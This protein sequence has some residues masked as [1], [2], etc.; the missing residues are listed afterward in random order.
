MESPLYQDLYSRDIVDLVIA[1]REGSVPVIPEVYHDDGAAAGAVD[2]EGGQRDGGEPPAVHRGH[3]RSGRGER[4]PGEV[5]GGG[6]HVQ[7][8][9]QVGGRA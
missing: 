4:D 2:Q 1:G 5:G 9:A 8:S 3:E 6:G 7:G